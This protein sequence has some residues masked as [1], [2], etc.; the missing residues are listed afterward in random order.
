MVLGVGCDILDVS[1]MERELARE[2][3]GFRDDVFTPAER[4]W[5]EKQRHPARHYAARFAAKEALIKA[6][7]Q[8]PESGVHW[9]EMEIEIDPGGGARVNLTGRMRAL[10]TELG[11]E[12][13]MVS[14]SGTDTATMAVVI[15]EA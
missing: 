2:G 1:R 9:S 4:A 14:F 3:G 15:T 6:L 13:I 5:C 8:I 10:A 12:R 11:V 7:G